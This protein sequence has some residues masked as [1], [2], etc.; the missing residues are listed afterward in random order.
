MLPRHSITAKVAAL[1]PLPLFFRRRLGGDTPGVAAHQAAAPIGVIG[2]P[3]LEVGAAV[4][5]KAVA[6]VAAVA[7][8]GGGGATLGGAGPL[9]LGGNGR[10]VLK[11]QRKQ[12]PEGRGA[13]VRPDGLRQSDAAKNRAIR[14][15]RDRGVEPGERA[16]K[17]APAPA[18]AKGQAPPA[19]P[20]L[21]SGLLSAPPRQGSP[22]G[23]AAPLEEPSSGS[24]GFELP[25]VSA[26]P[27]PAP[28][29]TVPDGAAT[30]GSVVDLD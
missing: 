7:L 8:V 13:T 16:P 24:S 22:Q 26:P 14:P 21:G 19:L 4:A 29:A 30:I 20:Q 17:K 15:D 10:T 11:E 5:G 6:V 2:A 9:D 27:P 25:A 18:K 28:P 3:T 12:A 1:L 23:E